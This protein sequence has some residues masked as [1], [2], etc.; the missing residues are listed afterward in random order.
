MH[1]S[2][3]PPNRTL[4]KKPSDL[5]TVVER[6]EPRAML[7]GLGQDSLT[8]LGSTTAVLLPE[9]RGEETATAAMM[10]RQSRR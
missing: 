8:G 5:L 6:L 1:R 4:K 10:T 3:A 2:N 9:G 7:A